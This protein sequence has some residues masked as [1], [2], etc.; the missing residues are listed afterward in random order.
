MSGLSEAVVPRN[1]QRV[2]VTGSLFRG[3]VPAGAVYVGRAAPGLAASP[4]RNM[5]AVKK[6][7]G[8]LRVWDTI[9]RAWASETIL[10]SFEAAAV[11]VLAFME[12]TRPGGK[13]AIGPDRLRA[14]LAGHDL[15]CWCRLE[16]GGF[17]VPCH[18]NVLL[19][20]ANGGR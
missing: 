15:A 18:G 8:G 16:D 19:A 9:A 11:A 2:K 4:Y 6:V 10:T 13:Y 17:P 1:P 7:D 14:D 20:L 12:A 5:F 3:V